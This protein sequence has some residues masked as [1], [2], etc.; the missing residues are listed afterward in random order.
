MHVGIIGG[1][2]M[3]TTIAWLLSRNGHHVTI[4][5]QAADLGGLNGEIHLEDGLAVAR[6]QHAILPIDNAVQGLCA[7][8]GLK[9][10]LSFQDART[11]FVH[12]RQIYPM[13]N[14]RDFLVFP[15]INLRDRFRLGNS[16][17]QA[18]NR[19]DWLVLD[20]IPVRQ[21]LVNT[22]GQTVFDQIWRPLLEAKFDGVYDQVAATY[23]WAWLNRMSSIRHGPK[24]EGTIGYLRGGHGS[25]IQELAQSILDAGGEI[26]LNTRVRE[27]EVEGGQLGRVRTF[28]SALEFDAVVAAMATPIFS[29]LVPSAESSYLR[30]LESSTYLGLICPVMVLD[31]PL[32]PYWT[33]NLTDPESPFSTIIST[34]HPGRPG[35]HIVYLPRYTAPDN[36]WMGVAD[37]DIRAAWLEHIHLIFPAFEESWIQH[38]IVSRARYAEPIFNIHMLETMPAVQTPYAGLYLAN[39]AQVY[40][41]LATS[42]AAVVHAGRVA[43]IVRQGKPVDAAGRSSSQFTVHSEDGRS[44]GD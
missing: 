7:E 43:Q 13:T 29:R 39:T 25:L 10:D 24:M 31:R 30:R 5:E 4:I 18:R 33:L 32:S 8:L 1:G 23:V 11:G 16:I 19:S 17:L 42:E 20:S 28:D 35:A 26:M 36:D 38:F 41:A 9:D 21:W 15:L 12:N 27:I 3:G 2:L 34:P 40:P 44:A 14:I 6:Y 37:E 22:C